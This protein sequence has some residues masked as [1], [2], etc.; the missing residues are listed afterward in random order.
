VS[1]IFQNTLKTLPS[2]LAVKDGL[3][4]LDKTLKRVQ[5]LN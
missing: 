1:K 2:G 4:G 3:L 5:I